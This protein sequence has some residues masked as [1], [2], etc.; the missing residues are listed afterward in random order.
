MF[1]HERLMSTDAL[2][3]DDQKKQAFR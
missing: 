3:F 2:P 1:I